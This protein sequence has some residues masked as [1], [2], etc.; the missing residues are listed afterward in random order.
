M[1]ST[2]TWRCGNTGP[3]GSP[4][5]RH[6]V[7]LVH[8]TRLVDSLAQ[9]AM[10]S[11]QELTSYHSTIPEN[12]GP[13]M[14]IDTDLCTAR[15]CSRFMVSSPVRTSHTAITHTIIHICMYMYVYVCIH[16]TYVVLYSFMCHALFKLTWGS[17]VP[18]LES[19]EWLRCAC[20]NGRT[21]TL[22]PLYAV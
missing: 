12:S 6:F 9:K 19:H 11:V 17:M 13:Y 5:K 14:V 7:Y 22:K 3:A 18:I 1:W 8:T 2:L 16:Y 21:E 10:C 15:M 4:L 20:V